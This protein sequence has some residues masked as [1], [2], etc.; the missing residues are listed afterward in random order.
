MHSGLQLAPEEL[1]NR[2]YRLLE[3]LLD[4]MRKIEILRDQD[5]DAAKAEQLGE[6]LAER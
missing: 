1:R 4:L 5:E 3:D 6:L 2:K